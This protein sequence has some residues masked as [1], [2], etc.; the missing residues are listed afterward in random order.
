MNDPFAALD[1]I[2]SKSK[3]AAYSTAPMNQGM[4]Y[5][6]MLPPAAPMVM[7]QPN[8]IG[9]AAPTVY[10]APLKNTIPN[11][12]SF[13][14]QPN[15]PYTFGA[16]L[17]NPFQPQPVSPPQQH[18]TLNPF[19]QQLMYNNNH[20]LVQPKQQIQQQKSLDPFAEAADFTRAPEPVNMT[21]PFATAPSKHPTSTIK[22]QSSII[23][24]FD[25]FSPTA[26]TPRT[27]FDFSEDLHG[28][29]SNKNMI[30]LTNTGNAA[31]G[32]KRQSQE[33]QRAQ[34]N[35]NAGSFNTI[36]GSR[37]SLKNLSIQ[38]NNSQSFYKTT[39]PSNQNK[40][41]SPTRRSTSGDHFGEGS[42]NDLFAGQGFSNLDDE[43]EE[44]A[45]GGRASGRRVSQ[46][47]D[48]E[49]LPVEMEADE[50]EVTFETGRKLGVLMERLDVLGQHDKRQE[51]AVVKLVV[52]NGSADRV[53]V[54][55][56]SIVV[57]INGR[58]V[59]CDSYNTILSTIKSAPRPM[60]MRFK[61]GIEKKDTTQGAIL[62]R[63][64]NG[65]FSVGNFTQGN[66]NW[67]QKYFAFGGARLDVLQLFVS[68]AA[69]HEVSPCCL[70]GLQ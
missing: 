44:S 17:S 39:T 59:A 60:V 15:G 33:D 48:V 51:R 46:Q 64:S 40:N 13:M 62:T 6:G 3:G 4:G 2:N 65:T 53:G 16:P 14:T 27:P 22:T 66:A 67:V 43:S 57:G 7:Q 32:R 25:P 23:V 31:Q 70:L 49:L 47:Q 20:S 5:G 63:I 55:V 21:S 37:V 1:P 10:Q 29:D 61:T 36:N 52:E 9:T 8:P 24:D 19:D 54:T 68:R 45:A 58:S 38:E 50:Y 30:S 35:F 26:T 12:A 28:N 41:H 34:L 11:G 42:T 56:G 18:Q 69:Y